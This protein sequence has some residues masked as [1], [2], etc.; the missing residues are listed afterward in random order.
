M[1]ELCAA[2]EC[3]KPASGQ[4]C[5]MHR[6]RLRRGGTL[7]PRQPRL[8]LIELL[9]GALTIGDWAIIGEGEPYR[10]PTGDGR[11]HPSGV[12]RTA[13]CRCGCGTI[14][15]IPVH[16]LKRGMSRHCGCKV[17]SMIT[18]AKTSHG[19]SGT[20]EYRTWT[21]MRA[22]CL[23]P[24]CGDWP[25]YGGRGISIC[26]RW[27]NSFEAF[28]A[29]MGERPSGT[30][31]DRIDNDGNYEPGNCRWADNKT[32]GANRPSRKGVPRGQ[33]TRL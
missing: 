2:P 28:F 5:S 24:S 14:R 7:A 3:G 33:R 29:D 13:R 19:M 8:S 1:A 17:S 30:S 16:I 23:S 11:P 12:Q 31:I 18:A 22:S 6:A 27:L 26:D 32:Q 9:G 10:R 21:H 20:A 4:Y 25:N 15:E